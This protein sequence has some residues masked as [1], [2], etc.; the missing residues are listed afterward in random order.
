MA[1]FGVAVFSQ[2]SNVE[3]FIITDASNYGDEPTNT[4]S[5]R[6]IQIFKADGTLLV[7][8]I[9]WTFLSGNTYT[10]VGELVQD[11]SLTVIVNWDSLSPQPGSTYE[12]TQVLTFLYYLK[13]FLKGQISNLSDDPSILNDTNWYT[14]MS[15]LQLEIDN[16]TEAGADSQQYSS[17]SAINRGYYLMNNSQNFF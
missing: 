3:N 2:N 11:Y 4:F 6:T 7:P 15:A 17:Q 10:V 8:E 13:Q 5:G 12:V 14:D 9:S 16:A 1:F